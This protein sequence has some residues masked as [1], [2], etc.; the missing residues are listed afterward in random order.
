MHWGQIRADLAHLAGDYA[1]ATRGWLRAAALRLEAGQP[2]GG[3]EV[4]GAVD[5]AHH[6]WHRLTDPHDVRELGAALA[7]LR[8]RVPGPAGALAD[9]RNRLHTVAAR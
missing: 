8:E 4:R 6:C 1:G 9:V 5:R 2:A 7:D 3:A